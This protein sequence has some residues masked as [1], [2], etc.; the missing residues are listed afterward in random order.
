MRTTA[1]DDRE[2]QPLGREVKRLTDALSRLVRDH[3]DLA[4]AELREDARRYAL[5]AAFGATALPFAFAALL[6]LD[7][8]LALGLGGWLGMAWGFVVVGALNFTVAAILG[9]LA[10]ERIRKHTKPLPETA[11][12]M[13]RNKALVQQLRQELKG[14]H[15]P[16][17]PPGIRTYPSDGKGADEVQEPEARRKELD[18]ELPA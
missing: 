4:K 9:G 1:P 13:E 14:Q 18:R 10:L 7:V 16:L 17:P 11:E 3:M 2:R 5:D 15:G 6:L 12:E 8:A